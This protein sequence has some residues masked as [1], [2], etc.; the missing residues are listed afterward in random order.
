[1]MMNDN[2][3][4]LNNLEEEKVV[5]PVGDGDSTLNNEENL[6]QEG[7]NQNVESVPSVS[8]TSDSK[9]QVVK[10][11]HVKEIEKVVTKD[12]SKDNNKSSDNENK[13]VIDSTT[14][15]LEEPKKSNKPIFLVLLLIFLLVFVFFLPD[16]TNF[17][18]N[19]KN[20]KVGANE[21]KSGN[22]TCTKSITGSEVNYNYDIVFKYQKNKLR[23]ST[24]TTVTRL[25]D[26]ASSVD[27]IKEKEASCSTLK[28]VLDSNNIGMTV[29]C[30]SSLSMQETI[31]NIYYKNLDLDY[32]S[33]NIAEFE[34]FYPEYEY[35]ESMSVIQ[36]KLASSGYKCE[37]NES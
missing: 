3:N 4:D 28:N 22:M 1:M 26:N 15:N 35:N 16:I 37:R 34:G 24:I 14:V 17:I 12:N 19:Y 7:V 8:S 2:N 30:K 29:K 32:I 21:L 10:V 18:T 11:E 23:S 6:N 25:N 5:D 36:N 31:Q 9:P 20:K 13:R 33:T 27:I